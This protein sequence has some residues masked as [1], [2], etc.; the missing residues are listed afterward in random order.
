MTLL[1]VRGVSKRFGGLQAVNDLS[2][3]VAQGSIK[4]RIG[5]NG[6]GKTTLFNLVSGVLDPDSGEIVFRGEEVQDLASHEIAVRGLVRT[7]QHIR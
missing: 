7:F 3:E 4:A 1:S 2:F 6:A 5:P